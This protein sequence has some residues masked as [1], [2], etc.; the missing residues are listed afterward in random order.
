MAGSFASLQ[1]VLL[2]AALGALAVLYWRLERASRKLREDLN[3]SR[4]VQIQIAWDAA[5][6]RAMAPA[7]A[8]LPKPSDWSLTAEFM[9]IALREVETRA[10]SLVV[11]LGAGLSTILLG[12]ALKRRGHGR[13]VTIEHD[14]AFAERMRGYLRENDL[15]EVVDLRVA[16]LIDAPDGQPAP[17]W[18]DRAVFDDV[19]AID[20][21]IVDGP[22]MPVHAQVRAPALPVLLPRMAHGWLMLVDDTGRAGE[23]TILAQWRAAYPTLRFEDLPLEKGAVR[24]TAGE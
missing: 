12:Y 8:V 7:D 19:Q 23:Q 9:Q 4:G 1:L 3:W 22:P 5:K 13:L 2:A 24:I 20:L 18:Y 6:L 16:P 21:L 10:P 11:E 14:R 17:V 15:L